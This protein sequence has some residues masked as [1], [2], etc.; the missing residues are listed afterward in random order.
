MPELAISKDILTSFIGTIL[1]LLSAGIIWFLKSAYEKHRSEKLALAK[2]ERIFAINLTILKDNFEFV[3]NWISALNEGRPYSFHLEKYFIDDETTF[4]L[5]N[6][7]L[8]N[9]II[10]TN[11]ML[12]RTSSDLG[13]I[14]K[15]YWE[16]VFKIEAMPDPIT[17]EANLKQYHSTVINALE[18]IKKNHIPLNSAIMETV[19]LV[20]AVDYVRFHS[21]FGYLGLLFADIFPR[22][23]KK[24]KEE[25]MEKLRQN[26]QE[27][28]KR[29]HSEKGQDSTGKIT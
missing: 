20:R 16:I 29:N 11:Y 22:A 17:K 2:F 15:G 13:N 18:Q 19:A 7:E 28:S 6:L 10:S 4:K 26:I 3:D 21:L 9:S 23:T 1:A 24:L 14:Y 12:R 5:S 8:I 27:K 25:E